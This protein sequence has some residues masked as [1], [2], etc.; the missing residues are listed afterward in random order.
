MSEQE[1]QNPPSPIWGLLL[2]LTAS[3]SVPQLPRALV[4]M[5]VR[6]CT[7]PLNAQTLLSLPPFPSLASLEVCT[8]PVLLVLAQFPFS[9]P[10]RTASPSVTLL[11]TLKLCQRTLSGQGSM[12]LVGC[13]VPTSCLGPS[14]LL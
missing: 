6:P 7:S 13:W 14:G 5:H 12:C 4:D 3:C 11:S 10:V 1:W 8:P 2:L 9:L